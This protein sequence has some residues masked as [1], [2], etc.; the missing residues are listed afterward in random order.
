MQI[1]RRRALVAA[2]AA[3]AGAARSAA[4]QTPGQTPG[5][6]TTEGVHRAL[7]ERAQQNRSRLTYEASA[8]GGPAFDLLVREGAAAQVFLIGEDHGI[9]ENPK[10][11]AALFEALAPHGY[12]NVG[13][14]IS[15]PMAR[16]IDEAL[17]AGGLE[18]LKAMLRDPGS[19][20]AFFGMAEEAAWLAR[21]R[22]AAP[23][24]RPFLWGLDYEVGGDRRLIAELKARP[25]PKAAAAAL[26]ALD[27]ASKASWAK[28]AETRGPQH[29]FS[30]AGD[31]ALVRAVRQAWSKP[32]ARSAE[33]LDTLEQTFAINA[34]W[35]AGKGYESNRLR[36]ENMKANLL[37]HWRA[38]QRPGRAPKALFKMGAYHMMRGRSGTNVYD[39]GNL[40][41]ELAA[42]E[43]GKSFSMLVTAGRGSQ[44]AIFDP[45][46]WTY[47]AGPQDG[48]KELGLEPLAEAAFPDAFTLIDLRPLRPLVSPS[49]LKLVSPELAGAIH[50]FDTL[51]VMSGSTPSTNL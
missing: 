44:T 25:K 34:A 28:Y 9:A 51:L 13:V 47:R 5:P 46:A 14:E 17:A 21:A 32:D 24:G 35:T 19:Q 49:R 23:R 43:G 4:A 7:L 42:L 30:F 50:G 11:A 38:E 41:P 20:V 15:P 39:V 48:L 26:D 3:L 22:A 18:G 8:F 27:Q 6:P 2:G 29:I 10:L 36:A 33:M 37:R 12:R 16:L 31:P 1:D 40:L 45:S